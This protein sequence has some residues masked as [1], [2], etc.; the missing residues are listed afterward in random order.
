VT[1]ADFVSTAIRVYGRKKWKPQLARDLGVNV[2]TIHRIVKREQVPGP[3]EVALN[4]LM[5]HRRQEIVLEKAAR[6]LVPR[7]FRKRRLA[8]GKPRPAKPRLIK[9][10]GCT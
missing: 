2:S 5:E 8:P 6:K 7:K 4:G 1:P 9:A 10:A 3:Y